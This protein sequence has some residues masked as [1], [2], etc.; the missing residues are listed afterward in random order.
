[1]TEILLAV[2]FVHIYALREV[3]T[4][5]P[6]DTGCVTAWLRAPEYFLG[7]GDA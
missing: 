1:M 4:L 5:I 7:Y 2:F 3:G 6:T